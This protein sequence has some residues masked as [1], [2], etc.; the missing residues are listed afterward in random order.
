MKIKN[1]MKSIFPMMCLTCRSSTDWLCASQ[2]FLQI[3]KQPSTN[4]N[5]RENIFGA[6][7]QRLNVIVSGH[8]K[9]NYHYTSFDQTKKTPQLLGIGKALTV[10]YLSRKSVL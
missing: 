10:Y 3:C 7:R 4:G 1:R 9:K 5:L 6:L 8:K 2:A